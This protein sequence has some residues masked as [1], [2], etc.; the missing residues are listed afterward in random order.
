MI[1]GWEIALFFRILFVC[2]FVVSD[3]DNLLFAPLHNHIWAIIKVIFLEK[4]HIF[5]LSRGTP[6]MLWRS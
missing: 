5:S 2:L 1:P 3:D 4:E 6:R